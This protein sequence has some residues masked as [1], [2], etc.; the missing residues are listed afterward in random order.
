MS[1]RYIS[2]LCLL[3]LVILGCGGCG[4]RRDFDAGKQMS[5]AELAA[6]KSELAAKENAP[7]EGEQENIPSDGTVFWLDGGKVYHIRSTCY[8]IAKKADVRTG[9]LAEATELG[10]ERACSACSGD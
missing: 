9:T 1:R 3:L 2:C 6:L 4:A 5:A 8:H 10:K 7:T